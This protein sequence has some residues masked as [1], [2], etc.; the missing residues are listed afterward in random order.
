MCVNSALEPPAYFDIILKTESSPPSSARALPA[1]NPFMLASVCS[2]IS[3]WLHDTPPPSPPHPNASTGYLHFTRH[4]A[5][6]DFLTRN[7]SGGTDS[8][9]RKVWSGAE[10]SRGLATDD[11]VRDDTCYLFFFAYF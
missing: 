8:V 5:T 11:A 9:F 10:I 7:T 6:Q 2:Q 1:V 3:D 4:C